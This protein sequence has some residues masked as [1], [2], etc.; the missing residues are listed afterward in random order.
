MRRK[1][2]LVACGFVFLVGSFSAKIYAT[3]PLA[4]EPIARGDFPSVLTVSGS[5]QQITKQSAMIALF[6]NK[7]FWGPPRFG[8]KN[9]AL[10]PADTLFIARVPANIPIIVD[11]KKSGFDR[12]AVGQQVQVQYNI[13]LSTQVGLKV[14]LME[15]YMYCGAVKI[16]AHNASHAKDSSETSKA[17]KR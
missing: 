4:L 11:G 16:D 10:W 3:Q 9:F 8:A 5:I 12:L 2:A 1:R 13:V 17:R 7:P 6:A 14:G 15:P